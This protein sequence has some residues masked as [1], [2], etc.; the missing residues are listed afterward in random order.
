MKPVFLI[1]AGPTR[2]YF[3]P[4]R[5]I[6]NPSSGKMGYALARAARDAGARV[7]LVSGPVALSP[8][9]GVTVVPV[10]TAIE[11]R[12]AVL[13]H[14]RSSDVVIMAAAVAD[15]RPSR[16]LR[17]KMK[18]G[19]GRISVAMVRTRDI[20]AEMGKGKGKT[21]LVGFAAETGSIVREATRKLRA[22]NLDMIVANNIS[23]RDSGFASD[24]NKAVI[25]HRDGKIERLPLMPKPRLARHIVSRCMEMLDA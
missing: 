22:K 25:L 9:R 7:V 1:T 21:R 17:R 4:V 2:E 15:Y 18:K 16:T 3:D 8:P 11:M 12:R 10:G 20:L 19:P 14:S 6:S 13:R 24:F 23:R 5:F